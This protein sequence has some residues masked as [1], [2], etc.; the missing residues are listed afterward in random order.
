MTKMLEPR[1]LF[2]PAVPGSTMRMAAYFVPALVPN[3]LES[4][5]ATVPEWVQSSSEPLGVA[6]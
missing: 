3:D 2:Q 4:I 1:C 6:A 5:S